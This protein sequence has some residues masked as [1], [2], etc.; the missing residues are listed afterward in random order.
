MDKCCAEEVVKRKYIVL[1]R[2]FWLIMREKNNH[3]YLISFVNQPIDAEWILFVSPTI[4]FFISFLIILYDDLHVKDIIRLS[5][6]RWKEY[7]KYLL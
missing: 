7:D 4:Q 6:V 1:D 3:P 5:F 2:P